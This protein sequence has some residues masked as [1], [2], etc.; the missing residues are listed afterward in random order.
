M[1]MLPFGL[2]T[3]AAGDGRESWGRCCIVA[4]LNCEARSYLMSIRKLRLPFEAAFALPEIIISTENANI[5]KERMAF[6][7]AR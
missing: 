6:V 2:N 4:M 5:V 3:S 7:P 1:V